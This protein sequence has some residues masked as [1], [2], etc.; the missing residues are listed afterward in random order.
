M[1]SNMREVF[2]HILG[3]EQVKDYLVN[4]VQKQA[5][6]H[7]L[8]FAGPEGACKDQ[9]AFSLAKLLMG[10][11]SYSKIDR[12]VHPDVH[13]Y[14]PEGK[15]GM[16]SIA[17]MRQFCEEVYLPP[18]ESPWKIF[19]LYDAERMLNY[20]ANA[21]LKTFEEPAL[22]SLIILLSSHAHALLPTILSRCRTIRFQSPNKNA[23][24]RIK[25]PS[26][27]QIL[28]LLAEGKMTTYT[29][30]SSYASQIAHQIEEIQKA[31]EKAGTTEIQKIQ[32]D[33]M[34]AYQKNLVEKETEGAIA[35]QVNQQAT[36][37][38]K[39]ILSWYRD[40]HLLDVGGRLELL[41]NPDFHKHLIQ[42]YQRG[43]ILPLEFVEEKIKNVQKSLERSTSLSYCLERLFLE[44]QLL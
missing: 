10:E 15:I 36:A 12:N 30:L 25:D 4:M 28:S 41:E 3:N 37:L 19:I 17:S 27:N 38:L 43:E 32:A 42:A 9:F 20:S 24:P 26:R 22:N 8:L 35:M 5:I 44:L 11:N 39:N 29:K 16:H 14:R 31:E 1:T 6:G 40:L 13:I 2:D 33:Q 34:N 7:S 23:A 21:L 18:Y